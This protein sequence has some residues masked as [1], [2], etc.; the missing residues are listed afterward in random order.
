MALLHLIVREVEQGCNVACTSK[1][2]QWHKPK[3]KGKI[4]NPD[5]I[6][7][8][9]VRQAKGQ[10]HTTPDDFEKGTRRSYDPREFEYRRE[11]KLTDFDLDRLKSITNGNCAALLYTHL[12]NAINESVNVSKNDSQG[13]AEEPNQNVEVQSIPYTTA[14]ILNSSPGISLPDFEEALIQEMEVDEEKIKHVVEQ[15]K[16]QTASS[17]W[18]SLRKGRIT[19]SKVLQC[20]K[21]VHNDGSVS[22]KNNSLLGNILQYTNTPILNS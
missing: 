19:A 6:K 1:P 20:T 8:V 10:F 13:T 11:K 22:Q 12:N 3:A 18:F 17:T 15:T 9:V 4:H 14:E 21:K 2:Q 5:F 7:N 16:S